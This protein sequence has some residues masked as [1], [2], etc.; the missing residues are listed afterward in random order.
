MVQGLGADAEADMKNCPTCGQPIVTGPKRI[1]ADC[2]R[3]ILRHDKFAFGRDG[4]VRHR[5]CLEPTQYAPE[6]KTGQE[7]LIV[8][9]E[10]APLSEN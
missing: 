6:A 5:V 10:C 7:N 8:E 2:G 4:R 9:T 3:P 1:C